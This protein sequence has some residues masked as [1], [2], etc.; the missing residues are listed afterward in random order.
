MIAAHFNLVNAL[1]KEKRGKVVYRDIYVHRSLLEWISPQ[2]ISFFDSINNKWNVI[3]ISTID[4]NF[5]LLTYAKFNTDPYPKLVNSC[6]VD[7]DTGQI[8]QQKY[9]KN[10]PI[11]HRKDELVLPNYPF[12]E[13]FATITMEMEHAGIAPGKNLSLGRHDNW[14][15][16]IYDNG[17]MLTKTGH[18]RVRPGGT[19]LAFAAQQN[20]KVK[21]TAI[22]RKKGG[23]L[24]PSAPMQWLYQQGLLVH[25]GLDYGC[26][27]GIDADIF[28]FDKYDPEF[29]PQKPNKTNYYATVVSNYVLN[30][31]P[32]HTNRTEAVRNIRISTG[33][34]ISFTNRATWST[35]CFSGAFHCVG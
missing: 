35:T 12:F 5:T 19:N 30:V 32:I 7:I 3:R 2:R 16:H 11:L 14:I 18:L 13:R 33:N 29:A 20:R 25:P 34:L 9:N 4:P 23:R 22:Q 28:G 27:Y 31:I 10:H 6:R 1:K 24:I 15:K 21:T 17:Y 26:G 8:K